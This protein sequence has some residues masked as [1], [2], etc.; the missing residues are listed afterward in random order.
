[1][2]FAS[3]ARSW[4]P[5]AM[6]NIASRL[7]HPPRTYPT[8]A[9][10][11]AAAGEFGGYANHDLIRI[12]L[13][14]TLDA[15]DS[16]LPEMAWEH[17]A[18]IYMGL[19]RAVIA[20]A[21]RPLRILDFGGSFGFHATAC[22]KAFPD[23]DM[24]WAV[25][26]SPSV[27]AAARPAE[28]SWLRVFSGFDDAVEW[29]DGVDMVHSSGAI[30]CVPDPDEA[31]RRLVNLEAPVLLWQRMMFSIRERTHVAKRYRLSDDH[32]G[33]GDYLPEGFTDDVVRVP[34]T[35]ITENELLDACEGR[36]RLAI[37]VP[38]FDTHWD[39]GIATFGT[40]LLFE[41]THQDE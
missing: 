12:T 23:I 4:A 10:A 40:V 22:S 14:K 39:S 3:I 17:G 5:P 18:P 24:R 6:W 21:S 16:G 35:Y 34:L 31:I 33:L 2:K 26:E 11:S 41:R 1:M 29:L 25:V 37:R 32:D 9:A 19:M 13:Q 27:A 28:C 30:Q 8:F 38:P 7:L 20:V 36:Y 15:R